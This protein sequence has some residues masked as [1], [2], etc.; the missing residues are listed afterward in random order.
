MSFMTI[1]FKKATNKTSIKH[2]NRKFDEKDWENEYHKHIDQTR[3]VDNRYLIQRDIH[4][5]Y[6]EIFG[7]ALEKYNAKQ[8]RKCRQIKD[9][10]QHVKKSKTLELQREFIVQV[11]NVEDFQVEEN[12]QKANAILT[13][14]VETFEER[15]PNFRVYN[16]VIHNDEAS[17]HL[18]INVIPVAT[19]YKRGMSVQPS[20]DKAIRQQGIETNAKD[21]RDVFRTFRNREID[22]VA[23][24]AKELNIDRKMGET[25]KFKD[26]REYKQYQQGLQEL[27]AD[28]SEKTQEAHEIKKQVQ[29][30]NI[31]RTHLESR[32]GDLKQEV[33]KYTEHISKLNTEQN[34]VQKSISEQKTESETL[35][36]QIL[37]EK[38]KLK[39]V[40]DQVDDINH[41]VAVAW[42]DDW[43]TT[44][45]DFPK[46]EMSVDLNSLTFVVPEKKSNRSK[47]QFNTEGLLVDKDVTLS[48]LKNEPK[49]E[50][51]KV[52][53]TTPE[54]HK[55][56]FR[57]TL[58][59]FG[60]KAKAIMSYIKEQALELED[61]ARELIERERKLNERE[62]ELAKRERALDEQMTEIDRKLEKVND[63]SVL[64]AENEVKLERIDKMIASRSE[65]LVNVNKEWS[66]NQSK[67]INQL[68]WIADGAKEQRLGNGWVVDS[69]AIDIIKQAKRHL[70]RTN[71]A[72][73][74]KANNEINQSYDE[75]KKELKTH[76]AMDMRVAVAKKQ[77][78]MQDEIISL[79]K[80]VFNADGENFAYVRMITNLVSDTDQHEY[81][82]ELQYALGKTFYAESEHLS[83]TSKEKIFDKLLDASTN[84]F[85]DGY[86]QAEINQKEGYERQRKYTQHTIN[87][88]Y[89]ERD[90]D[91]LSL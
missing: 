5:M 29:N 1:S 45:K 22:A 6:D 42:R 19:G 7:E 51:E 91:G 39:S 88:R 26:T 64:L 71:P 43:L 21:S 54:R 20:F 38:D 48:S 32:T 37:I 52:D 40:S 63:S 9:Y 16:A 25:N 41:R 34:R 13:K 58:K 65:V 81:A 86:K 84:G 75:L 61:K 55:F 67:L 14:Y 36:K 87:P 47:L 17:P 80:E 33:D 8:S 60:E 70:E 27:K 85:F 15:N 79:R 23:E 11:G 59:L 49:P 69:K 72:T 78:E 83:D 66:V 24:L 74:M 89:L 82:Y 77:K 4:E 2:N 35:E 46:F 68:G 10:Y 28:I 12:W 73:L 62:N 57:R 31:F 76:T 56:D 3:T 50:I 30:L 90:D 53:A 18:H 44:K